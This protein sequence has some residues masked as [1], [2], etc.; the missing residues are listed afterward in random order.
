MRWETEYEEL[1][2][3]RPSYT[4]HYRFLSLDDDYDEDMGSYVNV[5]RISDKKEFV[6]PLAD[7]EAVDKK[8]KNYQILHDY[9]VWFVNYR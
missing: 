3:T 4:D 8:S 2:K 5:R 7:L 9:S 1:K 6:L